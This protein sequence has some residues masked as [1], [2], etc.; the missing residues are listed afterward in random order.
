MSCTRPISAQRYYSAKERKLVMRLKHGE[1]FKPNLELPCNKCQS[2]KLRK[3]KEWALRCWHESQMHED[4]AFITLTYR[5]EDLPENRNLDHRD[6]QLFMKRLRI[7]YPERRFSF[8]MCGEYGGLTHRPHYHVVIFGYWPPDA[9]FHRKEKGNNYFKSEELDAFWKKGFTDTSYVSYQSAGYVA[10]Y[11][12]KKQ[13]PD[14]AL[15]DRY[16][17]ADKHGEMQVRKFEYTRMSTDP[18]IGKS[19]FEKYK[20]QT[21]RDDFVRDPNGI[22][23]PVPRY[24]L[25]QLKKEDPEL[26]EK[27]ALARIEKAKAS[28]DNTPARLKAKEICANARVKQLPRP[29]L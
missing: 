11:T 10:R 28:P 4:S 20:E 19:W 3:A 21:I 6:F 14:K 8:F 16:V 22:E 24:Y 18:A 9:K 13:L 25:D 12:L 27:L 15:Q 5:D 23:C 17:Y 26:H 29:Y 7:K 1:G 2:C